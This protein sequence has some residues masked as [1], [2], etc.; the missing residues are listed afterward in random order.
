M[1][2]IPWLVTID[3]DKQDK[4]LAR[5][6]YEEEAPGILNRLLAGL[7]DWRARGGL[8]PPDTAKKAVEEYRK[9]EDTLGQAIKELFTEH[10]DH[11][12]CTS[13]CKGHLI[14]RSGDYLFDEYR[15]WAGTEAMGRKTF[16]N[17]LEARG[18]VRGEY[19]HKAMFP[20]LESRFAG[21]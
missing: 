7:A 8:G 21:E 1:H 9:N 15:R 4:Y 16:Y 5:R 12:E 17:K 6:L 10:K 11:T 19:Q 2:L 18:Y 20:Q 14:N 3:K 13:R